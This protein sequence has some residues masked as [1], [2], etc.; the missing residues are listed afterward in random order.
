MQ[1][2][3]YLI[4]VVPCTKPYTRTLH[5]PSG[6]AFI[7]AKTKKHVQIYNIQLL[8]HSS[9]PPQAR[10]TTYEEKDFSVSLLFIKLSLLSHSASS[11]AL[12]KTTTCKG[13]EFELFPKIFLKLN[14]LLIPRTSFCSFLHLLP[15]LRAATEDDD[16]RKAANFPP[17][18]I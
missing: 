9:F 2:Y 4:S 8:W 13:C 17:K 11:Y 12:P 14:P 5:F 6:T 15:P 10:D 7:S 3:L 1:V 16:G 18:R